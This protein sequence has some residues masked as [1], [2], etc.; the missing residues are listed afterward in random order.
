MDAARS[1]ETLVSHHSTTRHHNLKMEAA[2]SPETLVSHHSTTQCQSFK[3]EAV[4]SSETVVSYHNT[5][6][7]QSFK[8]ET[9]W[10]SETVVSYHTTTRC[11]NPKDL[12]LNLHRCESLTS[13]VRH[14]WSLVCAKTP[15]YEVQGMHFALPGSKGPPTST[16]LEAEW[17]PEL[18]LNLEAEKRS[19]SL[20]GIEALASIP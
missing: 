4:W 6:R 20:L 14:S 18:V 13:H 7:C 17:A 11:H 5:T 9:V 2:W 15:R 19:V 12:D 16:G 8:M 10:S 1:S 3:M